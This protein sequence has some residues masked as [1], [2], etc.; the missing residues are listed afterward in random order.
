MSNPR[1]NQFAN[2]DDDSG[3]D[4]EIGFGLELDGLVN[5]TYDSPQD[6]E[7]RKLK[8]K[9]QNSLI[10]EGDGHY[11]FRRFEMTTTRVIMPPEL[12]ETE[13][14]DFGELLSGLDSAVNWWRGDWANLYLEGVED[15]FERGKIYGV[16]AERF[17][18]NK[19]T[20]QNCASVCRFFAD[21]SHRW[22]GLSFSHHIIVSGRD[23]AQKLLKKA[24]ENDWSKA[25][26]QKVVSDKKQR[27]TLLEK[28]VHEIAGL[29]SFAKK[30]ED[31]E[32]AVII[33]A[34]ET[35]IEEIRN[36]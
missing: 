22:E 9:M 12:T 28:R 25:E 17:N 34:L 35:A 3:A 1:N 32:K 2:Y 5:S 16:L 33:R 13:V 10:R 14:N 24:S 26:L 19:K 18:M 20:L 31:D 15:D 21:P 11:R 7:N 30:A 6:I 36:S 23:D 4:A 8:E 27:F 29:V